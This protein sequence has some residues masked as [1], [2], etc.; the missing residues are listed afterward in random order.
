MK[1]SNHIGVKNENSL[2]SLDKWFRQP[3]LVY[4]LEL[5]ATYNTCKI[6]LTFNIWYPN[7]FGSFYV[8]G[9]K[10][11]QKKIKESTLNYEFCKTT[12]LCVSQVI[13]NFMFLMM[14]KEQSKN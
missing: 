4:S 2:T 9:F 6:T 13:R 8:S 14:R 3:F 7:I 11:A 10:V 5:D 12:I 1:S